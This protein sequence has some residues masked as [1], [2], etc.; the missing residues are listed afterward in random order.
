MLRLVFL[1]LIKPHTSFSNA[2]ATRGMIRSMMMTAHSCFSEAN[3]IS[4]N[5]FFKYFHKNE[6]ISGSTLS[7]PAFQPQTIID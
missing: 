2:L 1:N 3:L 5:I 7:W 4:G 6:A